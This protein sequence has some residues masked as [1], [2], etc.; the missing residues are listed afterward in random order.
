MPG[1]DDMLNL[2]IGVL[3]VLVV[4]FGIVLAIGEYS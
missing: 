3:L 2:S 1:D 4:L